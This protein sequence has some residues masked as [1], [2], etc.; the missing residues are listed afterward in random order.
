[1]YIYRGQKSHERE[2]KGQKTNPHKYNRGTKP[3]NLISKMVKEYKRKLMNG[4]VE[5]NKK[6]MSLDSIL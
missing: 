4:L 5:D 1:M 2:L 6:N 3:D